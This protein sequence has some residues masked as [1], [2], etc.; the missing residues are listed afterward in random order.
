MASASRNIAARF[1]STLQLAPILVGL[2]RDSSVL[3]GSCP[4]Q[5]F[6]AAVPFVVVLVTD[7]AVFRVQLRLTF[8]LHY[9]NMQ[10]EPWT[11]TSAATTIG[12]AEVLFLALASRVRL[13]NVPAMSY[14]PL[15]VSLIHHGPCLSHIVAI[16]PALVRLGGWVIWIDHKLTFGLVLVWISSSMLSSMAL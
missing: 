10:K 3:L 4:F 15:V 8:A 9:F 2:F 5:I 6:A 1:S 13:V 11:S 14:R 7:D 16:D 12:A